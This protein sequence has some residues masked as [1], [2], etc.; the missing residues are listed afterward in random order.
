MKKLLTSIFLTASILLT[1]CS[2]GVSEGKD[3]PEEEITEAAEENDDKDDE[4]E[5][6]EDEEV[7]TTTTETETPETTPEATTTEAAT[8]TTT[9]AP[10]TEPESTE[11]G[12]GTEISIVG[13]GLIQ[14]S[15][16]GDGFIT[17]SREKICE[18][19]A[20]SG[21]T[22][23][24]L[25]AEVVM[26]DF[27]ANGN[28]ITNIYKFTMMNAE[29][30]KGYEGTEN[31]VYMTTLV[32]DGESYIVSLGTSE[33]VTQEE[34]EPYC[35]EGKLVEYWAFATVS[36]GMIMLIPF[37]A[38]TENSGYYLVI[39]VL[40]MLGEDIT[41]MYLP[42]AIGDDYLAENDVTVTQPAVTDVPETEAA[43][44][45][46]T[47]GSV[48][49]NVTSVDNDEVITTIN[50]TLTNTYDRPLSLIGDTILV[51]GVDR[52]DEF[53]AYFNVEANG[54][55]ED[56]FYLYSAQ[57][58][59]GDTLEMVFTVQDNDT[60]ADYGDMRFVMTLEQH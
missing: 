36:D 12:V 41:G 56:C 19:L 6:D 27:E 11:P 4:E 59:A 46:Q 34:V 49:L 53:V 44:A 32:L 18:D 55:I 37:I 51:N 38:G 29:G 3:E 43:T 23:K 16:K 1:S 20:A 40:E 50:C 14:K 21:M 7:T 35:P 22:E 52:S 24:E 58:Y 10:E 17:Y 25:S 2:C 33:A 8:T 48:V 13:T 5:D 47:E 42:E 54:S 30:I 31:T 45:Q 26:S 9:T 57:L 39:P 28:N 15:K 60:F